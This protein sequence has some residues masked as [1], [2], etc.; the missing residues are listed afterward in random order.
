M[1]ATTE[2]EDAETQRLAD[3]AI[4][5][6]EGRTD[7]AAIQGITTQELEAVY[8]LAHGFY[9]S[10]DYDKALSL[11][12]FLTLHRH[13]E[14]RYWF[15]LA[16]TQQMMRQHAIAVQS[17]G[18]CA[19]LDLDNPQTPLR[20]GEC[21]LAVGDKDNARSALEA[22]LTLAGSNPRHAAHAARARLILGN[23][24]TQGGAA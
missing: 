21:F 8:T 12:K 22:A 18:V 19:M 2:A 3:L 20:A 9:Q 10:G 15:G 16:A 1:S 17:Y 11:F 6:M 24:D 13:I 14:A 23:L 7:L 4:E 5:I